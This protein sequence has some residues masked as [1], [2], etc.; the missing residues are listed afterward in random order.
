MCVCICA[1]VS[2]YVDLDVLLRDLSMLKDWWMVNDD[3][4]YARR[5]CVYL[6]VVVMNP[7]C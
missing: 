6:F 7:S 2:V 5:V 1:C 4:E 3:D